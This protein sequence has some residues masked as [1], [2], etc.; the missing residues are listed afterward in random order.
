MKRLAFK[1]FYLTSMIKNMVCYFY[2]AFGNYKEIAIINW[3]HCE[4]VYQVLQ[5]SL[6]KLS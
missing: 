2:Q 5:V 1:K 3:F 6:E 4:T